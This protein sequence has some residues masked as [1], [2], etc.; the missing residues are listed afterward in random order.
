MG[1]L[2][3]H[4]FIYCIKENLQNGHN[5]R[6]TQDIHYLKIIFNFQSSIYL[7]FRLSDT[8]ANELIVFAN[9]ACPFIPSLPNRWQTIIWVNYYIVKRR[10]STALRRNEWRLQKERTNLVVSSMINRVVR[11]YV[12]IS[13]LGAS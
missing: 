10:M 2:K 6:R 8:G 1:K 5:F 7:K 4:N 9:V 3:A 11:K 12:T 13:V